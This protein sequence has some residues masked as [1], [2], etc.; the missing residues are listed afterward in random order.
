MFTVYL[1]QYFI[2]K[3]EKVTHIGNFLINSLLFMT[4]MIDGSYSLLIDPAFF[5]RLI[6]LISTR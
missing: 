2:S 6:K 3:K 4:E 1:N 5:R